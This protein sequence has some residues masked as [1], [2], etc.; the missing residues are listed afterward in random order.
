M[1]KES[2][3]LLRERRQR[4]DDAIQL[5]VPD[6]VPILI[7]FG[8]FAARNAGITCE[9]AFYDHK[10]WK[11]AYKKTILEYQPDIYRLIRFV[12]GTVLEALDCKLVKWPG[13]GVPSDQSYQFVDQEVM[14]E[15]EYDLFLNDPSDFAIRYFIPRVYGSLEPLGKLPPMRSLLYGLGS[16]MATSQLSMP[17]MN[18]AIEALFKASQE[19][20]EWISSMKT[21]NTETE[22]LGF[23]SLSGGIAYAPFDIVSDFLRGMRPTMLDMFRRPDKIVETCNRLLPMMIEWGVSAA[24]ASENPMIFMPLHRGSGGFM[25]DEQ[26]QTFY[27]PTLKELI[28]TFIEKGLTPCPFFEGDCTTRLE[29]LTELPKGKILA[30]FDAT[31]L[32]RAKEIIG[33]RICIAGNVPLAILQTGTTDNVKDYCRRVIDVVGKDG[34]FILSPSG[35]LDQPKPQNL[36]VMVQFTKDYGKYK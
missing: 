25:S 34:G 6:R 10:K 2:E 20:L 8:F 27:W 28:L 35:V 24:K 21:F 29:Y 18:S 13:H 33:K 4:V 36:K 26:F 16:A 15:N 19:A 31:D 32:F 11:A 30:L 7:N 22:A 3:Q 12:P 17:Q 5:K 23:P 1:E 9:Q 14:K